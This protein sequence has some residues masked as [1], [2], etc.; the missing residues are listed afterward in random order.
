MCRISILHKLLYISDLHIRLIV[1]SKLII[2]F[3]G[4]QNIL[5]RIQIPLRRIQNILRRI[6]R[7]LRRIQNILRRIQNILRRIQNILRRIQNILRIKIISLN[8]MIIL[9]NTFAIQIHL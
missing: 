2:D 8:S 1:I 3:Q 6:Q 4:I 5:R 9:L 7:P